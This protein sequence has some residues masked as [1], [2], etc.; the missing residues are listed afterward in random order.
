MIEIFVL[1]LLYLS[2][3]SIDKQFLKQFLNEKILKL[4]TVPLY[5]MLQKLCAITFGIIIAHNSVLILINQIVSTA[6]PVHA[7]INYAII[8][9]LIPIYTF[10]ILIYIFYKIIL[11]FFELLEKQLYNINKNTEKREK[12]EN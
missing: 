10:F 8:L 3:K 9:S 7:N 12:N 6:I 5:K 2:Y 4:K 11:F 1:C